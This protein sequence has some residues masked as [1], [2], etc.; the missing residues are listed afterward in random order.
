MRRYFRGFAYR[1][2]KARD[3]VADYE[4]V[5]I[6]DSQIGRVPQAGTLKGELIVTLFP[7][8]IPTYGKSDNRNIMTHRIH[9]KHIAIATGIGIVLLGLTLLTHALLTPLVHDKPVTVNT[10]K[11]KLI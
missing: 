10:Q 2:D 4:I 5:Y 7:V 1:S 3:Q 6:R 8:S 11:S 9:L